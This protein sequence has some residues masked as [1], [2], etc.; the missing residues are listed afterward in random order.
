[1][2]LTSAVEKWVLVFPRKHLISQ[3]VVVF[4]IVAVLY[5]WRRPFQR[6][7]ASDLINQPIE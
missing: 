3:T 2:G 1:V 4:G 7:K 5:A 6:L